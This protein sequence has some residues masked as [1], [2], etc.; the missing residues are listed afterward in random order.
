MREMKYILTD[1]RSVRLSV[2]HAAR[3]G[4]TVQ[5]WL[6]RSKC[7]LGELSCES[8]KHCVRCGS[9]SP[10]REGSKRCLGELSCE[11]MKLVLDVSSYPPT[12]RGEVAQL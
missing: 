7:C 8:M 6:N 11:P 10:R 2:Y 12:E 3:L 9:L 1:V 5:K 4:F